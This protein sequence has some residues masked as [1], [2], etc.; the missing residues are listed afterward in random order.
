MFRKQ[1][2]SLYGLNNVEANREL[3]IPRFQ[4][5]RVPPLSRNLSVTL[6]L[7]RTLGRTL[8]RF[9]A[10]WALLHYFADKIVAA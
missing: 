3:R 6:S 1:T 7:W 5:A 4:I 2:F 8:Q 10:I 9:V